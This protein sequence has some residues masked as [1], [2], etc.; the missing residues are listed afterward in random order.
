MQWKDRIH[1]D[2][3][4]F[5]HV[6]LP[7]VKAVLPVVNNGL[8][9]Y[10][11]A[12]H[13][14]HNV[15]E[16]DQKIPGYESYPISLK[17]FEPE[18]LEPNAPCLV[19]FH[20]GAFMIHAAPYHLKLANWYALK[21][22]CKVIFVDYRLMP[23]HPFPTSVEDCYAAL[24]WV[25]DNAELLG[26]DRSRIAVGGDSAGGNLASVIALLARDR[27]EIPLCFQM[28]IYPVTDARMETESMKEFQDTP[29]W[30]AKQ[31]HKMWDLYLPA[32]EEA[33]LR[34]LVSPMEAE[35]LAGL[36]DAYVEVAELDCLR[37][38]GINYAEALA[39]AG[40]KIE[41]YQIY[42][43]IHGFD[44]AMNSD[45]TRDCLAKRISA[46]RRAFNIHKEYSIEE[47]TE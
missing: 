13:T 38:E 23:N 43:A 35:S 39:K 41:F 30:N 17:I 20:G 47:I 1:E 45:I 16:S 14:I 4:K 18:D 27:G 36:P 37:D 3:K 19:Y 2:F 46:L 28:L 22:P 12:K 6:T 24:K 25:Y 29:M 15:K 40:S 32:A 42:R 9:V 11:A 31:N 7:V 33:G 8:F 34:H 10:G 5:N 26:I 44:M 21:T